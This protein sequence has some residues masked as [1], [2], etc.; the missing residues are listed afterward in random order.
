MRGGGFVVLEFCGID[1]ENFWQDR[2]EGHCLVCAFFFSAGARQP[3]ARSPEP[4]ARYIE[5]ETSDGQTSD[6]RITHTATVR[7]PF[8]V[9]RLSHRTKCKAA[10]ARFTVTRITDNGFGGRRQNHVSSILPKKPR[11]KRSLYS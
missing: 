1:D 8:T 10:H 2:D 7:Y 3:G 9:Y 11:Q 5:I 6:V 4:G